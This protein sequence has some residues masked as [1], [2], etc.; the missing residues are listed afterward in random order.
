MHWQFYFNRQQEK[1]IIGEKCWGEPVSKIIILSSSAF[2]WLGPQGRISLV[3]AMS[4]AMLSVVPSRWNYFEASHWPWDPMISF[5][6]SHGSI[7]PQA[8]WPM[9]VST[10]GAWCPDL[11]V[12][13]QRNTTTL[14]DT[15]YRYCL[16]KAKTGRYAEF[17]FQ[18]T[19]SLSQN[20]QQLYSLITHV[21]EG[22]VLPIYAGTLKERLHE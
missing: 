21:R 2:Q 16:F 15:F 10:Q 14:W 11:N 9:A 12:N 17:S 5:Q 13:K 3:V 20:C 4:I 7:L 19:K 18:G 22:R 6:A 1:Q 8:H